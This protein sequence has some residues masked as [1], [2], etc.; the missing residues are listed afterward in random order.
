LKENKKILLNY[1]PPATVYYP[2]PSLSILK[3]FL[4]QN[5]YRTEVKYWN[6]L[7]N[8][9]MSGK[10]DEEIT[11]YESKLM[12]FYALLADNETESKIEAYLYKTKPELV[13]QKKDIK[14]YIEE[15]KKKTL[16]IID[17]ELDKIDFN[18]IL[19]FGISYK[20][21]QLI[22][23]IVLARKIKERSKDTI[24]VI[25]G[26]GHKKAAIEVMNICQYF[27]FAIWGEGE[28]P[29]LQ[30]AD[31]IK[32]GENSFDDIPRLIYRDCKEIK[33]SQ[34][35][36]SRYLDFNDY[37]F[38]DYSDYIK[39]NVEK[40][41]LIFYPI[42]SIRSCHWKK[43]KFCNYNSGY[44]YRERKPESIV[45]EIDFMHKK[46]GIESFMFVDN[47]LVGTSIERF[48]D[49]LDK[50]IEHKKEKGIE[51]YLWAEMI[52]HFDLTDE[53]I[54]KMIKADF[55]EIFV[56]Y[57]AITD[58]LLKKM[59]KSNDFALNILMIKSAIKHGIKL[60]TNLIKGVPDETKKDVS[61]SIKNLHYLRFFFNGNK[62]NL[63]HYHGYFTL[64]REARYYKELSKD[65]INKYNT[66][67]YYYYISSN[68]IIRNETELFGH[69]KASAIDNIKE[70]K[71]F[72]AIESYYTK[73]NFRYKFYKKGNTIIYE[74]YKND[75]I[76]QYFDFKEDEHIKVI[77]L[78]NN[79]VCSF[80]EIEKEF[81]ELKKED[82]LQIIEDLKNASLIYVSMD[83]T[84]IIS[85][86][87][88]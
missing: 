78:T 34:L 77:Q 14:E 67:P 55:K 31:K 65:E 7:L 73:N 6:I 24:I 5:N 26:I 70:W 28:Y 47:D 60:K 25:G 18:N 79:K 50:L 62:N 3:S 86:I 30:L 8:S 10:I 53:I 68:L 41:N 36:K 56:G 51:Y 11:E 43:C 27:D 17:T 35:E 64:Y 44:K 32:K 71:S 9:V 58:T 12:P 80:S 63:N 40:K 20:L 38:P 57:E 1:L 4:E 61:D 22:P 66:N 88:V 81:P 45:A 87:D 49:L 83:M 42:N 74:E 69:L 2:S 82:L 15:I 33:I 59:G 46:Y 72:T 52:P 54:A 23:G 16:D 85:V 76:I 37:I 75:E 13:S 84:R 29:L 19:L 21:L 48:V 39:P